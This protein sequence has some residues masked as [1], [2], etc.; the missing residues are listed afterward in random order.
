MDADKDGTG[1]EQYRY[2][3]DEDA[4]R[5]TQRLSPFLHQ[6]DDSYLHFLLSYLSARKITK[7]TRK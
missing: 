4:E 6:I 5:A 7:K 1:K 3:H 2:R